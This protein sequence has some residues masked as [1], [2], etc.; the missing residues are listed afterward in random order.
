MKKILGGESDIA[1]FAFSKSCNVVQN[2]WYRA[3]GSV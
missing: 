1:E 2:G 3:L